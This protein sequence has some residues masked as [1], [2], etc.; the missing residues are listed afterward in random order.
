MS[1]HGAAGRQIA[2]EVLTLD[3]L[4]QA[5]LPIP[6]KLWDDLKNTRLLQKGYERGLE[7]WSLT[8]VWSRGVEA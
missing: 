8:S 2:E 4:S 6:K 5:A 7:I 3:H 1:T